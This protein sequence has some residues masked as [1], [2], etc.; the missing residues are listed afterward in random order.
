MEVKGHSGDI[1]NDIAD[2]LANLAISTKGENS[3]Y[4]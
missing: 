3:N 4:E 2:D 1:G